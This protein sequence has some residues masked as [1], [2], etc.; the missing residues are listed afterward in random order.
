M[1]ETNK[2]LAE[3]VDRPAIEKIDFVV[4]RH[5]EHALFMRL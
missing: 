1:E 5:I 3:M 4:D 2:L